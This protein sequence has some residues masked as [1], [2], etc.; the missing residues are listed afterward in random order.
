MNTIVHYSYLLRYI[1]K[2]SNSATEIP[3]PGSLSTGGPI[4]DMVVSWDMNEIQIYLMVMSC[5]C[6]WDH[7]E[8]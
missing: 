6:S 2:A 1:H 4:L 8:S 7:Q 5:D 3:Q